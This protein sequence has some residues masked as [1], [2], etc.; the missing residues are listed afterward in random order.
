MDRHSDDATVQSKNAR[1][2]D[3]MRVTSTGKSARL[4]VIRGS[5]VSLLGCGGGPRCGS[6]RLFV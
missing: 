6:K 5:M 3:E 2:F 4:R 1:H